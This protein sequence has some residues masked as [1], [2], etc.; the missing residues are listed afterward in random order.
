[1]PHALWLVFNQQ[2]LAQA[3]K[4]NLAHFACIALTCRLIMPAVVLDPELRAQMRQASLNKTDVVLGLTA[5]EYLSPGFL[6]LLLL[7]EKHLAKHTLKLRV[8]GVQPKM[9]RLLKWVGWPGIIG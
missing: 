7:L 9:N 2:R 6:G 3:S 5:T 4:N 1:M 8:V